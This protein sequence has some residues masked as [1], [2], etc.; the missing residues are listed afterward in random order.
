MLIRQEIE[1]AIV[2]LEAQR[3]AFMPE[4]AEIAIGTLRAKLATF[5]EPLPAPHQSE[6]AILIADMSGFTS[7]SEFLDAEEVRDMINAVWQKL[8]GV[9]DSWGGRVDKH[10]GDAVIAFFGLPVPH[11]D[12]R[13]RA[14]QAALDMQMELALFN[15]GHCGKRSVRCR[16]IRRCGCAL[17]C[18]L[19]RCCL[20]QW[21]AAA[22]TRFWATR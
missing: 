17:G 16:K 12:D 22:S 18:I 20:V 21:A 11:E 6:G 9:I 14:V 3:A 13:E 5:T 10:V 8:D 1:Q 2:A 4:V 7:L 15:D 19:A